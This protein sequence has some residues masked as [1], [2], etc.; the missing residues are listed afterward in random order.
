M[1]LALDLRRIDRPP[2]VVR[3]ARCA[4]PSTVPSSEVDLDLAPSARRSA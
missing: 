1:D 4:A 2:D 3:G